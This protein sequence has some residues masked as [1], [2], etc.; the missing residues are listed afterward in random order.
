MT[1]AKPIAQTA[2]SD[3]VFRL[4]NALRS[5]GAVFAPGGVYYG[6]T[7]ALRLAREI[8]TALESFTD[9]DGDKVIPT[10]YSTCL[11]SFTFGTTWSVPIDNKDFVDEIKRARAEERASR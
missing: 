3:Y 8:G 7:G 6:K 1:Q 10:L 2:A 9:E 4:R 11:V 5:N